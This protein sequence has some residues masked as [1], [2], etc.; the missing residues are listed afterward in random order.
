M[1]V[2]PGPSEADTR[3]R[4][5]LEEEDELKKSKE[6]IPAVGTHVKYLRTCLDL[7]DSQ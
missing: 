1:T 6:P 7:E 2:S 3:K 4:L 5:A